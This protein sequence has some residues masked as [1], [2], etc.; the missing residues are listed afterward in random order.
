[1]LRVGNQKKCV[2]HTVK[3]TALG[4]ALALLTLFAPSSPA[5]AAQDE[6][7]DDVATT[8]APAS[9][10]FRRGDRPVKVMVL[11]GSIGSFQRDPYAKRIEAMCSRIE[12]RNLSKTG[13]SAI[14][15]KKQFRHQITKNRY[16]D[17]RN[18]EH[19]YWLLFGGGLN[20]VGMPESSNRHVRD[21]FVRAHRRG[22]KIVGMTTSP[23]GAE[24]DRRR[25]SGVNGLFTF[26]NTRSIVDFIMKRSDPATAL[27]RQR[28]KRPVPDAP[29]ASEEQAEIA[30]DLYDS[31][32]RDADAPR[33]DLEK[34]R[35]R[36]G[37]DKRW[38][39]AHADLSQDA[40]DAQLEK[41]A[42]TA[43]EI[44]QWYMKKKYRAFDHT[45]P[46]TEGHRVIAETLCPQ[47]PESWG[48]TCPATEATARG[49]MTP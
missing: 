45:H 41:D 29:W 25:W 2:I 34:M 49:K 36:L 7:T 38:R 37:K 14:G 6:G 20:S 22:I 43:A 28:L 17:L 42:Q 33:R 5:A 24:Y 35:R 1:M 30:V 46:N 21:I 40:R 18:E 47:M 15:L 4:V 13:L 12:V 9:W 11:A 26:N 44:P 3:T 32:L 10:R 27:G 19:E 16:L 39:R 23:W 8:P 31:A 48:C